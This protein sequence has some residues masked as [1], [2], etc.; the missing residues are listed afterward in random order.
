MLS[1][2]IEHLVC[3][4]YGRVACGGV[5]LARSPREITTVYPDLTVIDERPKWMTEEDYERLRDRELHDI[6]GAP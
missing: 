2:K 1:D 5:F 3:Y 4:N 6:D